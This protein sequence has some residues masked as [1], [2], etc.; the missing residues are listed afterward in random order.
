[1]EPGNKCP[2]DYCSGRLGG[3]DEEFLRC[4]KCRR[5]VARR[6]TYGVEKLPGPWRA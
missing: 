4:L 3:N 5:K 2:D 1:M 6:T